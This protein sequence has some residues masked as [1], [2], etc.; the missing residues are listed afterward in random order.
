[1]IGRGIFRFL[2]ALAVGIALFDSAAEAVCC[3]EA[4][5]AATACH[6]CFCGPRL[7]SSGDAAIAPAPA[8]APYAA[9]KPSS[10][11]FLPLKSF[12]RPPCLAA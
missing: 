9:F 8:A 12:F 6:A 4:A 5:A 7:V 3:D 11:S 2:C 1:M 10:Y